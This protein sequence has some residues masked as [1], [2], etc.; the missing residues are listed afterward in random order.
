[1]ELQKDNPA[2]TA[3]NQMA[4]E[5]E[6]LQAKRFSPRKEKAAEMKTDVKDEK[7]KFD[8]KPCPF[9]GKTNLKVLTTGGYDVG[10]NCR[11]VCRTE[12]CYASGIPLGG[13]PE[14]EEEAVRIWNTRMGDA[15]EDPK[16]ACH[17]YHD[18]HHDKLLPCPKCGGQARIYKSHLGCYY[19]ACT[20][21][22]YDL[23]RPETTEYFA[24]LHWNM[25]VKKS[26]KVEDE[27]IP[28]E[29]RDE[30]FQENC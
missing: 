5:A 18:G 3:F 21:C 24:A 22:R 10:Y 20:K 30:K 25:N 11:V 14:T 8:L 26:S 27:E 16:C 7:P 12:G 9:C 13:D 23:D 4:Q 29:D 2:V 15:C 17:Q 28:D 6:E 19:V 1:M